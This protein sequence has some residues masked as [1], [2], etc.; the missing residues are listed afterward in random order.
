MDATTTAY[1]ETVALPL[2]ASIA[3][4]ETLALPP[5]VPRP[6]ANAERFQTVDLVRGFALLGILLMNIPGF[7]IDGSAFYNIIHG[8][9]NT[10]D[11]YTMAA[12]FSFFDGTMRGLFSMLFGA[13]MVLFTMNK[14][15]LE[16]GATVAEYYY[17]RLLWLVVFGVI[18]AYV[19]LWPGDIL[20]YYGLFGMLLYP[21]RKAAPK[22]LIVI[23][24]AC[25][26]TGFFTQQLGYTEYREKRLE[27]VKAISAEKAHVKLTDKQKAAKAQWE[28]IEKNRKPDPERVNRDVSKM[29]SGYGV[30]FSYFTERNG[31]MEAMVT[32]RDWPD[33][34]GMMFIGMGLLALGFF[35]NKL[36]TSTYAMTLLVGYGVGIPIGLIF[37]SKGIAVTDIGRYLDAYRVPHWA[38]YDLRRVL[39]SVGHASLLML[40][41]TS[42]IIPWLMKVLSNVGQMAFTNYLMQSIICTLIFYGYGLGY[43]NK[44]SFHQLYYIVGS[45]WILQMIY[46][47]I[48]LR[49][50][51]FGPFEWLWRSL[52]YWKVQPMRIAAKGV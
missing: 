43:Y 49:Y 21:F 29:R 8:P 46:S 42:R 20:F 48:W 11:Y 47:S 7:G 3:I 35:S 22:W 15:E 26:A 41:F 4:S 45:V 33:M 24:L 16:G 39:L 40:V 6:V 30:M 5:N 23:G 14:K 19:L 51:R 31:N 18:N 25:F 50:Y 38:L 10:A 12:I 32:Y 27:Y 17:R 2:N 37:F 44:L 36:S 13:G 1:N 52:T 28:E 9:H 34:L